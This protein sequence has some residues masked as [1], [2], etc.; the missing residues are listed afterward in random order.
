MNTR[1]IKICRHLMAAYA[2]RWK[3]IRRDSQ[4]LAVARL[5]LEHAIEL[6]EQA[7]AWTK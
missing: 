7:K 4:Q 5:Y 6:R 3:V 2:R 1:L